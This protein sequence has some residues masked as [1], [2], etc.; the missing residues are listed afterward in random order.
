MNHQ[1]ESSGPVKPTRLC[2]SW[3]AHAQVAG[4]PAIFQI[5][6]QLQTAHSQINLRMRSMS[7]VWSRLQ[8]KI[9]DS[10]SNRQWT[11]NLYKRRR[12]PSEKVI[13]TA[14]LFLATRSWSLSRAHS[15]APLILSHPHRLSS[16]VPP[17]SLTL[18]Y[19]WS[20]VY[21][22]SYLSPLSPFSSPFYHATLQHR[23]AISF[24]VNPFR[25][26]L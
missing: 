12:F 19:G 8:V 14:F 24:P 11:A 5:L 15:R 2:F 9:A 25:L 17:S 13:L 18:P 3:T 21:F 6:L 1:L 20:Y 23:E 26:H 22:C 4:R 16:C 7:S 10:I